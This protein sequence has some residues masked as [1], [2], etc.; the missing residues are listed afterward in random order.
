MLDYSIWNEKAQV[1]KDIFWRKKK[2][3]NLQLEKEGIRLFLL[4]ALFLLS[5]LR[6]DDCLS[7]Q[8]HEVLFENHDANGYED[9]FCCSFL[10]SSV[11]VLFPLLIVSVIK[12]AP[13]RLLAPLKI[14]F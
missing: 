9:K 8:N 5:L 6:K 2:Q 10:L 7:I 11:T 12:C 14:G 4:K 1:L 13:K 3:L